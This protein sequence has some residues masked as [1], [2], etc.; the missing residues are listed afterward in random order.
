METQPGLDPKQEVEKT[1]IRLRRA[2]VALKLVQLRQHMRERR[3]EMVMLSQA[4]NVAWLTAGASTDVVLNS[5]R[6][7][8]CL[9]VTMDQVTVLANTIEAPRLEAEEH[10]TA[11]GLELDAPLWWDTGKTLSSLLAGTRR[12]SKS[13]AIGGDDIRLGQDITDISLDLQSLR[14]RLC[15]AEIERLHQAAGIA[16]RALAETIRELEPGIT[17]LTIAG[18]LARRTVS[19]GAQ[20]VVNLVA[21]DQRISRYRHPLPTAKPVERYVMLV[22]CASMGGLIAAVTRLVHFGPLPAELEAK[23]HILAEIDARLIL[24]TRA[25][26]TLGEQFSVAEAA[27]REAGYPEAIGEHHQ[28]GSIGYLSR[29]QLAQPGA[30]TL[31]EP[32]QAFAWNP[33]LPGVKSE[34]T[35]LVTSSGPEVLTGWP[36]WPV[37]PCTYEGQ[38][39]D[40]PAILVR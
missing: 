31:I 11:L 29:E 39:L 17:E 10:L 19:E 32:G 20:V 21:S 40:R 28:G 30:T 9:W 26:R 8:V 1:Q 33:S 14:T 23:A 34:D 18:E 38:S 6:S 4:P 12:G 5:D 36:Q 35:M 15:P 27:Y 2:E 7:G 16:N 3:L 25:G 13:G 24:T 22:L 37:I